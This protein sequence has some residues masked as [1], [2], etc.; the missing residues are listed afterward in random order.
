[1]LSFISDVYVLLNNISEPLRDIASLLP[2][3]W[4]A[5]ELHSVFLPGAAVG[6]GH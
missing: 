5:Q 2:L 1:M 4:L 3:K 6:G